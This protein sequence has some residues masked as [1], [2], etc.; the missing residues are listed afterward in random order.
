MRRYN[1][2]F[3]ARS[4]DELDEKRY[5]SRMACVKFGYQRMPNDLITFNFEPMEWSCCVSVLSDKRPDDLSAVFDEIDE[6]VTAA[7]DA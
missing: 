5:W 3:T 6:R 2:I 4:K 1:R 7:F